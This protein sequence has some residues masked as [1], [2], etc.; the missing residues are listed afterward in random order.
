[1][2]TSN[3]NNERG[4]NMEMRKIT[5]NLHNWTGEI[6]TAVYQ[7]EGNGFRFWF[8]DY[9]FVI[10]DIKTDY[11]DEGRETRWDIEKGNIYQVYKDGT[12]DE[13]RLGYAMR[14]RGSRNWDVSDGYI[15]R[16]DDNLIAAAIQLISNIF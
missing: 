6:G 11:M 1:M 16:Q 7:P 3:L 5:T 13:H 9:E 10:P 12:R 2:T 4:I 14:F 15:S 8:R